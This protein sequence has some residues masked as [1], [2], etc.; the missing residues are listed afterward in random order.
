MHRKEKKE[1]RQRTRLVPVKEASCEKKTCGATDFRGGL[2]FW[3]LV[4]GTAGRRPVWTW[5]KK[6]KRGEVF[7][8][9]GGCVGGAKW[10]EGVLFGSGWGKGCPPRLNRGEYPTRQDDGG[11]T[12]NP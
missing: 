6:K 11:E 1:T 9:E 10:G 4:Q 5:E 2:L 7:G 8:G 3:G 12:L